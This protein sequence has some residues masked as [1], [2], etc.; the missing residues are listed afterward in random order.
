MSTYTIN[1]NLDKYE[2][3]DSPNLTDQYN[4]AMDKIDAQMMTNAQSAQTAQ[5]AAGN[6]QTAAQA[7]QTAATTAQ[8]TATAA[9]TAAGEAQTAATNAQRAADNAASQAAAKAPISHASPSLTYGGATSA[10]YGHVKLSDTTAG[11]EMA[12]SSM[13]ATPAAVNAAVSA[14]VGAK[15]ISQGNVAGI[16]GYRYTLTKAGNVCVFSLVKTTASDVFQ[17]PLPVGTTNIYLIPEQYRPS[18]TFYMSQFID[19]Q[20]GSNTAALII[21]ATGQARI[22]NFSGSTIKTAL[23]AQIVWTLVDVTE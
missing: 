23:T 20:N 22:N 1:Y 11:G 2:G 4:S 10:K 8:S 21:D 17:V 18:G 12:A 6:A 9:S 3:T 13:A 7:A 5:T 15:V 14:A 16:T 19:I